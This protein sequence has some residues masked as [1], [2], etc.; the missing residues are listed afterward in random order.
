MNLQH[1]AGEGGSEE[2]QLQYQRQ[3]P[4]STG[5]PVCPARR[6]VDSPHKAHHRQ[7]EVRSGQSV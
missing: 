7:G 2:G 3:P 5:N 6:C 4:V 1:L